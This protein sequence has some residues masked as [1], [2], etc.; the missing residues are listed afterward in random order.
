MCSPSG[1]RE[2]QVL[3]AGTGRS[4]PCLPQ[5]KDLICDGESGH[6]AFGYVCG[7]LVGS[8]RLLVHD[9]QLCPKH[10]ASN[11]RPRLEFM[12]SVK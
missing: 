12:A 5:R 3:C 2:V 8:K 4:C 1:L 11:P 6:K 7:C 9:L 10:D